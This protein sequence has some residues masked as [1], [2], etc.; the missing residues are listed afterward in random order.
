MGRGDGVGAHELVIKSRLFI[1]AVRID[2][3]RRDGVGAHELVRHLALAEEVA[4]DERDQGTGEAD[5][6]RHDH[7]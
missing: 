2:H 4:G 3:L 5:D 1:S 6:E 7:L